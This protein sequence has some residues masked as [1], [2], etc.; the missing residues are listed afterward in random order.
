MVI[1]AA[2]AGKHIICEKPLTGYFGRMLREGIGFQ[3]RGCDV[4]RR[5]GKLPANQKAIERIKFDSVMLRIGS[6]LHP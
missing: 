6:M 5:D 1:A 3:S 4:Q 2:E